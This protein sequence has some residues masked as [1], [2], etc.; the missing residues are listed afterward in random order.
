MKKGFSAKDTK[1]INRLRALF[2]QEIE[3][4]VSRSED[5]G[6]IA[7]VRNFPGVSTEANTFSELI[8]M[9]NDALLTYFE[10][11][12]Q[13]APFVVSYLPPIEAAQAAGIY[14]LTGKSSELRMQRV[15]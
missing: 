15:S 12:A 11:P 5:G 2:P 3:V 10:I 9:V 4:R 8:E 6:F 14:P 7:A 1:E 13:Y